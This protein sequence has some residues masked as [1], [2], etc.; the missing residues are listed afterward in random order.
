MHRCLLRTCTFHGATYW[1]S[2][3]LNGA[4]GTAQ[5]IQVFGA[6]EGLW[7]FF[8]RQDSSDRGSARRWASTSTSADIHAPRGVQTNIHVSKH[9]LTRTV[10]TNKSYTDPRITAQQYHTRYEILSSHGNRYSDVTLCSSMGRCPFR[11]NVMPSSSWWTRF[12]YPA[13]GSSSFL[14]KRYLFPYPKN[15]DI[16]FLQDLG[17]KFSTLKA[18]PV[19][20]SETVVPT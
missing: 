1:N 11:R 17:A 13:Q 19:G 14:W 12:L 8:T 10:T 16:N 3:P 7:V 15:A 9:P 6:G 4:Y 5:S 2:T 20:S 18:D